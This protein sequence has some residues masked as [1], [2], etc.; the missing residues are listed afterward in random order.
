MGVAGGFSAGKGGLDDS[1]NFSPDDEDDDEGVFFANRF[2][3]RV[4]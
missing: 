4:S 2:G 1:G 3:L